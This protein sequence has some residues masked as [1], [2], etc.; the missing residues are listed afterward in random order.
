MKAKKNKECNCKQKI[1]THKERELKSKLKEEKHN[2]RKSNRSYCK[3]KMPQ[4]KACPRQLPQ[5][6]NIL[7][8]KLENENSCLLN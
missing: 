6:T 1:F 7:K 5:N 3:R 8:E 4:A 2:M